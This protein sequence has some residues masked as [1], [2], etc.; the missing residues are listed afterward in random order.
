MPLPEEALRQAVAELEERSLV[1]TPVEVPVTDDWVSNDLLGLSSDPAVVEASAAALRES[2]AGAR[3][4]RAL[5]GEC[6]A[7]AAAE[8]AA[9]SWLGEEAALLF[10]SGWQATAGVLGALAGRGDV[11]ICDELL[12]ASL[13]DGARLTRARR[14]IVPHGDLAAVEAA[15]RRSAGA[16]RRIL[17]TEGVYSMDG[18]TPDLVALAELAERYDAWVLVDEAHSAGLLGPR[19]A[20][21][22]SASGAPTERL[23]ARIVTGGKALGCMGAFVVGSQALRTLLFSAARSF[24][25]TTGIAPSIA[26]GLCAS[27]ERVQGLDAERARVLGLAKRLASALDLPEPDAA[28]VPVPVG[29]TE[30]ALELAERLRAAGTRVHAVRPP[31]VAPGT[32]RLRIVLH[33]HHDEAAVDALAASLLEG[34]WSVPEPVDAAPRGCRPLWITGT[35]TDA[36]KTVAAAAVVHALGSLGPVAY[37]KPVQT[38][39]DSDTETVR[40]LV[41]GVDAH[42]PH[43]W[44]PLPASPH[45]AAANAGGAIDPQALDAAL[46]AE[47]EARPSGWLVVEPAGGLHVPLTDAF[48]TSDWLARRAEPLVLVA[49]S[50]LG[51]LNHTLLSVEA[52]AARG[53]QPRALLL[54]GPP[55]P[56]NCATLRARVACPVFEL[57]HLAPLSSE[58]VRSWAEASGLAQALA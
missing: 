50:G 35:D 34:G 41:P 57:P 33:A 4:A 15:L 44:F 37:W 48:L 45:E 11:L 27:I 6:A 13:I 19:G 43:A 2:G 39:D 52:L 14:E 18:T 16:R 20:G 54:V 58:T 17:V 5:G 55:H 47:L 49:R 56:S 30:R 9:A 38:G 22:W 32:A 36:G 21:A 26:A 12:H 24:L 46:D 42:E 7:H 29:P 23:V 3:A 40:S 31:T 53:L 10:P 28:I 8:R 1:R 51:T 25:F